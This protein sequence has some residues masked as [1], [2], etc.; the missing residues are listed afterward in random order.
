MSDD[1]QRPAFYRN[2]FPQRPTA[3]KTI[4]NVLP[5]GSGTAHA[6]AALAN[7]VAQLSATQVGER[8]NQL[9]KSA[10]NLFQLVAGG[11]LP[12]DDAYNAL[13][14]TALAVGLDEPGVLNTLRSAYRGGAATPREVAKLE[15]P[16]VPQVAAYTPP[17]L[18]G[19]PAGEGDGEVQPPTIGERFP[20]LDWHALWADE[21]EEEWVLAPVLPARRLVA[22]FSP[23]KVGKSLLMLEMAVQVSR[24]AEMFGYV[25][26]RAHR[27]LYV[28]FENDPRGDIR[29]RLQAMGRKPQDLDNLFYLSYPRL[30]AMDTYIGGLELLAVA[31]H[32]GA[33]VVVIDTISRAVSGEENDNDTWLGFYRHTGLLLKAAGIATIRLDH[34][35]KDAAKGMRGGSAKYGDVDAVW[36][37][38]K[39]A[40]TTFSLECTAN[41][42]PIA[43]KTLVL[44]RRQDPHLRHTVTTKRTGDVKRDEDMRLAQALDD[45]GLPE[46]T[47][48]D[49]AV[50]ELKRMGI[51]FTH[52]RLR[53]AIRWRKA[54]GQEPDTP[55]RGPGWD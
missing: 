37:M 38:T 31:E 14:M 4:T 54:R 5:P 48:H 13:Y 34:T 6:K 1:D 11:Y 46:D 49:R 24:G 40:E 20:A 53:A 26:D 17:H 7:E 12:Y 42:L 25:P 8:N 33:E 45:L 27:V 35:G 51:Q 9:N 23:P 44:E 18:P 15:E 19:A 10:F 39:L 32:Y 22:L 43:E 36:A 21:T 28:D 16:D 29:T 2:A 55:L 47:G 3:R 50:V 41:R 52:E 30:A